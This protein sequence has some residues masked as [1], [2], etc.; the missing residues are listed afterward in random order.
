METVLIYGAIFGAILLIAFPLARRGARALQTPPPWSGDG[1]MTTAR[2]HELLA[3]DDP[4]TW[5]TFIVSA[6]TA[7]KPPTLQMLPSHPPR[8]FDRCWPGTDEPKPGTPR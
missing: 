2:A 3:E 7:P 8:P 6:W 5:P 4:P 1:Y